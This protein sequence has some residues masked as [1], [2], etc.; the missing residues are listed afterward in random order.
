MKKFLSFMVVVCLTTTLFSQTVVYDKDSKVTV[1][2]M[3]DAIF[4]SRTFAG[5]CLH[6]DKNMCGE[7]TMDYLYGGL[8]ISDRDA[9]VVLTKACKLNAYES[10]R[11]LQI[12]KNKGKK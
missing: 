8:E 2:G 10:C 5:Q 4:D 11:A 1:T 7:F 6:G 9:L 12:L 3:T